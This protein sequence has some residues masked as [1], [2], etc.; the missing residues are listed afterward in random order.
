MKLCGSHEFFIA[1]GLMKKRKPRKIKNIPA[2]VRESLH[3]QI[4]SEGEEDN[5]NL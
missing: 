3:R 5:N 1:I 2:D 4:W